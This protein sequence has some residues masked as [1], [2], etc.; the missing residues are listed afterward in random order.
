MPEG[1]PELRP[2]LRAKHG[3]LEQAA[4]QVDEYFQ[5]LR[6]KWQG[7]PNPGADAQIDAARGP[8]GRCGPC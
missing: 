5:A 4:K 3:L 7:R 2:D 8:G 6:D 1:L